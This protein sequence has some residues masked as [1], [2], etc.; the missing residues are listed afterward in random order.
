MGVFI[1][2]LCDEEVLQELMNAVDINPIAASL[3]FVGETFK[4]R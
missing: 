2:G 4:T 1:E 3:G